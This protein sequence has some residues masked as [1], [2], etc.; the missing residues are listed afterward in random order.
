MF[1]CLH[2]V[3]PVN[4]QKQFGACLCMYICAFVHV[5]IH[6][7]ACRYISMH[8]HNVCMCVCKCFHVWSHACVYMWMYIVHV[9]VCVCTSECTCVC[10]WVYMYLCMCVCV[11]MCACMPMLHFRQQFLFGCYGNHSSKNVKLNPTPCG[12]EKPKERENWMTNTSGG[13]KL[14]QRHGLSKNRTWKTS[15]KCVWPHSWG[16]KAWI[17]ASVLL[18][19]ISPSWSFFASCSL[20]PFFPSSFPPSLFL[21]PFRHVGLFL[22]A[23]E[24]T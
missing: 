8:M 4:M 22:F 21:S 3:L 10:M 13:P 16:P 19:P 23:N 18:L 24:P 15:Q 12:P 14:R 5:C 2:S 11:C 1:V 7:C 20:T 6:A 9:W 17:R